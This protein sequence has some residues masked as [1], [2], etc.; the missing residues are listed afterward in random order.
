MGGMGLFY[1]PLA[2]KH[3]PTP[4]IEHFALLSG[5]DAGVRG[6]LVSA[7]PLAIYDALGDAQATSA[8]YFLSGI[9]ALCWG[10][11]VPSATRLIPRRWAYTA[12]CLLYLIGAALAISGLW[13]AIA[14]ALICNAMATA[15]IFICL[16]AYVLDYVERA[17]LGRS[18]SLQMAYAATPWVVGPMLG[19]WLYGLWLP[20]PFLL[21]GAFALAELTMF[22]ILRLGNGKQ[23]SR[24]RRPAV[25]PL[26]YLGR[27]FRQPRLIAGWTFQVIRSC[28]WWVYIVYLPIFCVENGLGDKVGG[29]AFSISNAL[30][31]VAPLINRWALR[32]TLRRAVRL[33]FATAAG[34]L[35]AATA[36][37]GLP[38][39]TVALVFLASLFFFVLDVIGGLPFLMA[40]RPGE[41]TEMSAVYSSFRDV[42]GIFTPG[43]G[44]LVLFFLP[45]PGI[46]AITGLAFL[47][48]WGLAGT[49]HPRLGV[50]RPS[51]GG[52]V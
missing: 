43:I 1:V 47:G 24:A 27:F 19:V 46:F 37:A 11:M 52:A 15:T 21:A 39:A 40:V 32:V 45:L 50:R 23:I 42:S 26:G 6:T 34:L 44:W 29:V 14:A 25:N 38:W 7:M 35:F 17:D 2:L 28:G 4:R 51:R 49:L 5:L 8:V 33:A 16:N 41:R 48:A 12:G 36:A 20:A 3:S 18:Q 31:F 9:A 30:L 13:W 10:L 22:W